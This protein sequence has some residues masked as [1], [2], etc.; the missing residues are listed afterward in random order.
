MRAMLIDGGVVVEILPEL[1]RR[2]SY[3]LALP[4]RSLNASDFKD[5]SSISSMPTIQKREFKYLFSEDG[6]DVYLSNTRLLPYFSLFGN[7]Q[8]KQ[9]TSEFIKSDINA[10]EIIE[11]VLTKMTKWWMKLTNGR[12]VSAG[13]LEVAIGVMTAEIMKEIGIK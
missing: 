12:E 6:F 4:P 7:K 11:S 13:E 2:Q 5:K 10:S 1:S 3:F 8:N 9:S